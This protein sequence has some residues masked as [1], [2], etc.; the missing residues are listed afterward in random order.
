MTQ[1][2]RIKE[3][4][5]LCDEAH[6]H[7]EAPLL[8]VIDTPLCVSCIH[9]DMK[10]G[11]WDDPV[12]NFYGEP[13]KHYIHCGRYDCPKYQQRENCDDCYLPNHMIKNKD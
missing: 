9:I 8:G 5:R 6:S 4:E 10:Y 11:T 7:L 2:E 3:Y 12:C 13:P 1:E